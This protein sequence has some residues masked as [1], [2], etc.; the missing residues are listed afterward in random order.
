MFKII[1]GVEL[2]FFTTFS[3]LD[4]DA[5]ATQLVN[6]CENGQGAP[7]TPLKSMEALCNS[8]KYLFLH[9]CMANS[10]MIL[11]S[12]CLVC[13]IFHIEKIGHSDLEK[14]NFFLQKMADF[15]KI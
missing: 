10:A 3:Y 5:V 2:F 8:Y 14:N 12:A 7:F 11:Y 9:D 13:Y 1:W 4:E 6:V 15:N